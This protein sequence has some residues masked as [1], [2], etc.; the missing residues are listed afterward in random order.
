MG[1]TIT[2]L[3]SGQGSNARTLIHACAS[4]ALPGTSVVRVIYNRKAAESGVGIAAAREAGIPT[5]YHNLLA[6]EK[7]DEIRYRQAQSIA[8][9]VGLSEVQKQEVKTRAR[10]R[11]DEALASLV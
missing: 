6:Y 7:E 9:E 1:H 10:L 5:T 2:I 3:L 8:V 4:P 11:Y